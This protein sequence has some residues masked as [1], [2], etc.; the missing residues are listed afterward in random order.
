MALL[1]GV[2]LAG[3]VTHYV[4]W[5]VRWKGGL[6]LLEEGAEGLAPRWTRWYNALLYTWGMTAAAAV[7]VETPAEVRPWAL[8]GIGAIPLGA[9]AS[10]RKNDWA[11]EQARLRPRWWNRAFVVDGGEGG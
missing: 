5:P 11:R 6:P 1:N 10:H 7:I 3:A 2:A 8:A 4:A 9:L